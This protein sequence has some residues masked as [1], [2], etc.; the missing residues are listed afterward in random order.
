M[1]RR[2]LRFRLA[3]LR[4]RF[5][6]YG[7][8]EGQLLTD[9]PLR[10]LRADARRNHDKL[11]TAAAAAFAEGDDIALEAIAARAGVGI[12]TLYRPLPSRH[13]P[14]VAPLPARGRVAVHGSPGVARGAAARRGAAPVDGAV[15]SVRR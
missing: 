9:R 13:A 15:R 3:P 1:K 8:E 6:A 11:L 5:A 2:G 14:I 12:G 4:P 10:P 7:K